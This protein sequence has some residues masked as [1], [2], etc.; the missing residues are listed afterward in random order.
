MDYFG[1][2]WPSEICDGGRQLP[3]PVGELCVLC[4]ELI[5]PHD[6]GVYIGTVATVDAPPS[7]QPCHRECEF[8]EVMGGIGHHRDHTYWCKEQHDPDGGLTSRQSA[9]EVW[10]LFTKDRQ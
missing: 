5:A 10:A 4:S 3:T 9:L 2:P 8:R 7:L 6:Q 1:A